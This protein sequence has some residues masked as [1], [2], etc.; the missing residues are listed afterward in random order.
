MDTLLQ[1]QVD[2]VKLFLGA[3]ADVNG[4]AFG[5]TSRPLCK[6]VFNDCRETACLLLQAKADA[7]LGMV[8]EVSRD[9]EGSSDD[10]GGGG[11]SDDEGGG[12]SDGEGGGGSSDDEGGGDSSDG[13][14]GGGA[15][16]T[17]APLFWALRGGSAE[18]F[19]VLLGA[20]A[21]VHPVDSRGRTPLCCI[22]GWGPRYAQA[23]LAARA[24][25]NRADA[26][27]RAPVW[28]VLRSRYSEKDNLETLLGAKADMFRADN[29]GRT[30][31]E[32]VRRDARRYA[33]Y[34]PILKRHLEGQA[35]ALLPGRQ[36][37]DSL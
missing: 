12:S 36:A 32:Y 33:H 10:E 1:Y 29:S 16:E 21:D 18:S 27:G 24:E 8:A 7:N 5:L 4:G 25:V 28:H 13:E 23:L 20:K 34:E 6:A 17:L 11:S 2:V 22:C 9:D 3:K 30:P 35:L 15:T 26:A 37:A 14:G 19:E 31:F